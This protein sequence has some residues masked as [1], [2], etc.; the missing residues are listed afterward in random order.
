MFMAASDPRVTNSNLYFLSR[1]C[2]P[3]RAASLTHL[4]N[5]KS[6]RRTLF[7]ANA[8]QAPNVIVCAPLV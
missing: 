7:G 8:L 3:Q 1:N 5:A 4:D 6:P 2:N